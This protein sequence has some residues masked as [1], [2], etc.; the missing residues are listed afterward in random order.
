VDTR[1]DDLTALVEAFFGQWSDPDKRESLRFAVT[2]AILAVETGFVEQRLLTAFAALEMLSWVTDVL[3]EGMAE[4]KWRNKGSAWRVRR[5]LTSAC[6]DL[7]LSQ[8]E[9]VGALAQF[10]KAEGQQDAL[11]AVVLVRDRVTHPKD[12]RDL[13]RYEGLVGQ[14]SRLACRY[15]E[16]AVLHRI[17]YNGHTADRTKLGGWIGTSDPAPWAD[18][19]T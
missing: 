12:V 5:L 2:S 8:G 11:G 17:G 13:Y 3:E 4:G 15:L 9:D 1:S 10:A 7:G 19:Q 6:V 16:L 18:G 14:A